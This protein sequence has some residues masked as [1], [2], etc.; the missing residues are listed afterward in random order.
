MIKITVVVQPLSRR[1]NRRKESPITKKRPTKMEVST[2]T[3]DDGNGV[4]ICENAMRV[5][6][7]SLDKT[8]V[9]TLIQSEW[10][11]EVLNFIF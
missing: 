4:T 7:P 9:V 1:G 6:I 8:L 10:E 3:I 2:T 11:M 5:N